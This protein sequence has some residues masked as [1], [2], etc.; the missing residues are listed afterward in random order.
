MKASE[1][2][3]ILTRNI[4]THGDRELIVRCKRTKHK[5][6]DLQIGAVGIC[7]AEVVGIQVVPMVHYVSV[8]LSAKVEADA[9]KRKEGRKNINAPPENNSGSHI[10]AASATL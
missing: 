6:E 9:A 2:V 1:V 7:G 8:N 10:D 4:Q 5:I 3:A